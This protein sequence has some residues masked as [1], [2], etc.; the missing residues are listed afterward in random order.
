MCFVSQGVDAGGLR[1]RVL[2]QRWKGLSPVLGNKMT[3]IMVPAVNKMT[4]L[5]ALA[6]CKMTVDGR[7]VDTK[8]EM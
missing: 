7:G 4:K 5:C 3:N 6:D 1:R 8:T 2:D